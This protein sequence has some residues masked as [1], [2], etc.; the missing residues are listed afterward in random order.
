M[1]MII[2]RNTLD[3]CPLVP[4]AGII[5]ASG[6]SKNLSGSKLTE[7][8]VFLREAVQNS[9]D[10]VKCEN[11]K[12]NQLIFTLFGNRFS[13]QQFSVFKLLMGEDNPSSFYNTYITKNIDRNMFN[14]EVGDLNTTGLCGNIEPTI[15]SKNQNFSN[16]VYFTGNDKAL[17]E[18]TG[19]SYGFGK[20]SLFLY[21]KARTIV[22][23]TRIHTDN[24]FES[25]FIIIC[26]DDRI[27][28]KST[29]RCWWGK[30]IN[31][32]NS[33][34]YAAPIIGDIADELARSLGIAP[35]EKN[36]TGTKI[37][38]VNAGP[39]IL[40]E[41]ESGLQKNISEV[42]MEDIPTYLL[43]WYWNK[44]YSKEILF[45]LKIGNHEISISNPENLY[46]YSC[47]LEAYKEYH[48]KKE[49]GYQTD[50]EFYQ[51]IK[52]GRPK[53]NIGY[54]SISKTPIM[55]ICDKVKDLFEIFTSEQPVIAFMRG[56]ENIVYYAEQPI[57][58]S[59]LKTTCYGVFIV[60]K[61]ASLPGDKPG[62]VDNYFKYIENQTHERWQHNKSLSKF[63][64][65]KTVEKRIIEF[66]NSLYDYRQEEQKTDSISV[67]IQREFGNK[68]LL[69]T[70]SIGGARKKGLSPSLSRNNSKRSSIKNNGNPKIV[71]TNNEKIVTLKYRIDSIDGKYVKINKIIPV[72]KIMDNVDK[73]IA[74]DNQLS[75]KEIFVFNN[76]MKTIKKRDNLLFKRTQDIYIS[77]LCKIDCIFYL[78][79]DWEEVVE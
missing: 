64:Y 16:F 4:T 78:D 10:A 46:P 66:L 58:N 42:F 20:G 38:V 43:H 5:S 7:T 29:G 51:V 32:E 19:G 2:S 14:I 76:E 22:V 77:V 36:E 52:H 11:G 8:E 13:E 79:I 59:N 47:F 69:S 62:S 35:F 65:L 75:I 39:S 40:P 73:I 23:Y 33:A 50:S 1:G 30:K 17:E 26:S 25:R 9:F 34:P 28:G 31:K 71:I 55:N 41:Y 24:N 12:K 70:G 49:N 37:L 44:I 57:A 56:I 63:D 45:N 15:E 53:V 48:Y 27:K 3:E 18:N 60:D 6:V 68:L 21:S 67:M 54:C 74:N 61:E 72:I